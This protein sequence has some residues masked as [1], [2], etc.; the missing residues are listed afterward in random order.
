VNKADLPGVEATRRALQSMLQLAH[1][2]PHIFRNHNSYKADYLNRE[3]RT[4]VRKSSAFAA[5]NLW[6]PPVHL[7]VATTGMGIAELVDSIDE[8]FAYLEKTGELLKREQARMQSELDL[9]LRETLIAKWRETISEEHY[10]SILQ[11]ILL[12]KMSPWQAIQSF[13][14][15]PER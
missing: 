13:L 2:V 14:D 10:E 9:L 6:I 4:E 8:H 3:E 15:I 1:P 7:T 5:D 12:R 11:R